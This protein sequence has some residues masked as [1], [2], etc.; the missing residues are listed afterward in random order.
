MKIEK[1]VTGIISTNC[2]IV[3]NEETKELIT[4]LVKTFG[5]EKEEK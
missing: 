4:G 5:E 1:F 2:Y 3:T